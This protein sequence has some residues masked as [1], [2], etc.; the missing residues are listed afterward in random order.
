MLNIIG[1]IIVEHSIEADTYEVCIW[2]NGGFT[3]NT[4]TFYTIK[5][6]FITGIGFFDLHQKTEGQIDDELMKIYKKDSLFRECW[7][8]GKAPAAKSIAVPAHLTALVLA[9]R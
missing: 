1:S 7:P 6:N 5:Q 8:A 9:S 4:V 2:L 3:I